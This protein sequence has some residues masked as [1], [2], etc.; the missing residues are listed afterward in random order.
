VS[1][2]GSAES[3]S[4]SFHDGHGADQGPLFERCLAAAAPARHRRPDIRAD[5]TAA[6]ALG[7]RPPAVTAGGWLQ[8]WVDDLAEQESDPPATCRSS[9][10]CTPLGQA[11]AEIEAAPPAEN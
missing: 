3:L 9:S 5:I 8:E 1:E 11:D 7:L 4:W 2:T 6:L 10:P